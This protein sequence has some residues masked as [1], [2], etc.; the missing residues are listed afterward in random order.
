MKMMELMSF[1]FLSG[2]SP[3][4]L[5]LL[6]SELLAIGKSIFLNT[7]NSFAFRIGGLY[8]LYGLYFKQQT[9]YV[10]MLHCVGLNIILIRVRSKIRFT[11]NELRELIPFLEEVKKFKEASFV[12]HKLLVG[13]AFLFCTTAKKVRN[14]HKKSFI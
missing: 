12:F 8:L 3:E 9:K 5:S 13:H 4:E 6:A 14:K 2:R 11:L 1:C 10:F 7:N